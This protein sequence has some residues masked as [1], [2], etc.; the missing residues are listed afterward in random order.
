V[1]REGSTTLSQFLEDAYRFSLENH[2][3]ADL[4]P[5]QL[6]ASALA[7][8]PQSSQIKAAFKHCSPDWLIQPPVTAQTWGTDVSRLEADGFIKGMTFSPDDKYIATCSYDGTVR[9]WD[10]ETGACL[11]TSD[12]SQEVEYRAEV[13]F[14]SC[15]SLAKASISN[16]KEPKAARTFKV[17]I[18]QSIELRD[19][20]EMACTAMGDYKV[21]KLAFSP[22]DQDILYTATTRKASDT[23]TLDL[24]RLAVG[25][26]TMECIWSKSTSHSESRVIGVSVELGLVVCLLDGLDDYSLCLVDLYSGAYIR[27]LK[28]M[29]PLIYAR[30]FDIRGTD[31]IISISDFETEPQSYDLH[32][33]N[34]QTGQHHLI[35]SS[36]EDYQAFA[37]AR[38]GDR[39]VLAPYDRLFAEVRVVSRDPATRSM[40]RQDVVLDLTLSIDGETLLVVY[41]DRFEVQTLQ[42]DITFT[43]PVIWSNADDPLISRSH[44]D[45]LV[46]AR[47]RT[48]TGAHAIFLWHVGSGTEVSRPC[49]SDGRLAPTFS[50]GTGLLA[51]DDEDSAWLVVWNI[52]GDSGTLAFDFSMEYLY[53]RNVIQFAQDDKTLFA[54][55]GFIR[56]D[57]ESGEWTPSPEREAPAETRSSR[58]FYK[59]DWIRSESDRKDLMWVP[60]H[61]RPLLRRG[62]R[63]GSSLYT[64][65]ASDCTI[66]LWNFDSMVVM[67]LADPTQF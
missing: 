37:L 46:A 23:F 38:R 50:H 34:I 7:F 19:A 6:Y 29:S 30:L 64:F 25:A 27:E 5:L 12:A 3:I 13:V 53:P 16:P 59:E 52:L 2:F 43:R 56:I 35:D 32:S 28:L 24:W 41:P 40:A 54:S 31:L 42:G 9:V 17:V 45:A 67:K 62:I 8:A 21:A 22:R 57:T 66:A 48:D 10:S 65:D 55:Q 60:P 58:V 63:R 20:I 4:A 26:G 44:D 49:V 51:Y 1:Q 61:Y 11:S 15:N 18:F 39:L 14:S 33:I 47:T 36:S